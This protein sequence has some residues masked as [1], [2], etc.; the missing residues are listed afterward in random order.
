MNWTDFFIK[1]PVFSIA[2]SLLIL[3]AGLFSAT[4]LPLQLL[5]T[6]EIPIIN[7]ETSYPGASSD[8]MQN[9]VTNVL[10]S[11]L[12]GIKGID[13]MTSSSTQNM[14]SITINMQNGLDTD[15]ALTDIAQKVNSVRGRLPDGINDPVISK[16]SANDNFVLL[17]SF[18]SRLMQREQVTDYLY[19]LVKPQLDYIDGVANAQVWGNE[20]AML[21]SLDP[22]ALAA[23]NLT[24]QD[25]ATALNNQSVQGAPGTLNGSGQSLNLATNSDMTKVEQFNNLVIKN[26]QGIVTH[27]S[28]VGYAALGVSSGDNVKAFYDGDPATMLAI[29]PQPGANP[30]SIVKR[31]QAV[32]PTITQALPQGLSLHEVVNQAIYIKASIKEVIKTL[33]EALIIVSI[34]VFLF[35]G[36]LRAVLIP[37]VTIP[38]SLIGICFIMYALGFSFNIL[39]LLAMV[40]AI[41]LVVDDA[42]VVMENTFR[43]IENG[44]SALQAALIGTREIAFSIIAMT[45]TLAAIFAPIAFATGIT[46]T[47]F[48]EFA[49]C[50]AGSVIISGIAA[51]TLSPMMC[52]RIINTDYAHKALVQKIEAVFEWVKQSYE[53]ILRWVLNHKKWITLIWLAS[54]F[55][56]FYFYIGANK[57]LA[58]EE[59]QGYLQVISS[60]PKSITPALLQQYSAELNTVYKSFTAVQSYIYIDG[61]PDSNQVLS[62]A[63]L[64]PW[65]DRTASA[66]QLQPQLQKALNQ[67]AGLKAMVILPAS[68]PGSSGAPVQF[69]IKS[70]GDYKSLYEATQKLEQAANK[71][72]LFQ[73]INSDL[74][75]D[76]PMLRIDVDRNAAAA[77]NVDMDEITNGVSSLYGANYSQYFNLQGQTYQVILQ[78]LLQGTINPEILNEIQVRSETGKLISLAGLVKLHTT[79]EPSTLNQFQ[80]MN[81]A[82]LSGV[83]APGHSISE[84]L[85]YLSQAAKDLLPNNLTTDISG[86]S[87][88][89]VQEGNRMLWLFLAS[90]IA[91]FI[92][93]A[94]QFESFRDPFI[95][96]LGSVPMAVMAAL[97]PIQLH[98]ATINIYTQIGLLTLAGLIS[99]HGILLVKFANTLQTENYSKVEAM[100]EAAKIRLRPILMTTLAI[101]FGSL[102]LVFST[103]AGSVARFD[104][105]IVIVFGTLIGTCF[106]LLVV[107]VLYILLSSVR[108]K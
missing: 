3:F 51:L 72:G 58:P 62:F 8:T 96:L 46:G 5:P 42:I 82:T 60:A 106:T 15:A 32:L 94:M 103:G 1:R 39:T 14:S 49:L 6:I 9:F 95:I 97:I 74:T 28:D 79:V 65:E 91:I 68:L 89:Y 38:V 36:S 35:L 45:L 92:V 67:I 17:L 70:I 19:R 88:Q 50:L 99:K 102:P 47:L 100:V 53:K 75:Y 98:I 56:C 55:L 33:I 86:G 26:Q 20:F 2:L 57:E 87:R 85:S 104:M 29:M 61:I 34:V 27:L 4:Q 43:H 93:L 71:S 66:M 12:S 69:V 24:P 101:V 22:N 30:L 44:E 21:L 40:L 7:I 18:T 80:R 23:H 25:V 105:G 59:D 41:G 84:G 13:Y 63:S 107:P 52:S 10:E 64:T 108:T 81:A 11:A 90:F 76:E 37:I 54:L 48:S 78:P 77:M 31:I 16:M 83:M 73:F